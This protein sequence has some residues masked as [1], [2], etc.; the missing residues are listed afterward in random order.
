MFGSETL[1]SV[2]QVLMD[3]DIILIAIVDLPRWEESSL[4]LDFT[5]LFFVFEAQYVCKGWL[6]V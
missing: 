4:I 1:M 5:L 2:R 6:M 3:K